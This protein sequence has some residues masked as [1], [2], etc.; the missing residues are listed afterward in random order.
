MAKPKNVDKEIRDFLYIKNDKEFQRK[1]R[2]AHLLLETRKV[3][4]LREISSTLS[5]IDRTLS[6]S[7]R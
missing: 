7:A 1:T 3:G 6:E 4:I 5:D 2:I